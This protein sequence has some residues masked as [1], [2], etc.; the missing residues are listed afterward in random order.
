MKM[1]VPKTMN[2]F[3]KREVNTGE[4]WEYSVSVDPRT[5]DFSPVRDLEFF[6]SGNTV[7]HLNLAKSTL[8]ITL[9]VRKR[10][11]THNFAI[12]PDPKNAQVEYAVPIDGFF[13]TM[14]KQIVLKL[15]N[16]VVSN[17][18]E[19][20]YRAYVELLTTVDDDELDEATDNFLYTRDTPV[21]DDGPNPYV[22]QNEGAIKR[23]NLVKDKNSIT[24][25]GPL[26]IDFWN[27]ETLIPGGV[28]FQLFL[29]P[30]FDKFRFHATHG[31]SMRNDLYLE[32]EKCHLELWYRTISPAA[33]RGLK[34][35]WEKG[36]VTMPFTRTE[37]TVLQ[38]RSGIRELR[39]PDL[40]S[41]NVPSRLV[42]GMVK[43]AA[44]VGEFGEN[45]FNFVHNHITSA[46]FH[47]DNVIIPS[48][49]YTFDM[50]Q[51]PRGSVQRALD[52][53]RR[54]CGHKKVGIRKDNYADQGKFLLVFNTDPTVNR[55]LD[56]WGVKRSGNTKLHLS[57]SETIRHEHNLILIATYPAQVNID[58]DGVVEVIQP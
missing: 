22:S 35:A 40:Y 18:K 44:Y 46:S 25:S 15:N 10:D 41:K 11:E 6:V 23:W 33:L 30:A 42:L 58:K 48:R 49:P 51:D 13:H 56:Y 4:T 45:P 29:T 21:G 20:P 5:S 39:V 27:Q 8:N 52:E 3:A 32:I 57:F 14:W 36:P 16:E 26:L 55:E 37:V 12:D 50:D 17:S 54:Y 31:D 34:S 7:D 1:R 47:L 53:F 9:R 43:E 38:L 2:Y 24:L 28:D 19:H